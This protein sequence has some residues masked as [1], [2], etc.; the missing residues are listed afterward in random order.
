MLPSGTFGSTSVNQ[1]A[2]D[3]WAPASASWWL[4]LY[5]DVVAETILV[6]RDESEVAATL[7]FLIRHL[8][9]E[10]GMKVFDQC[11]GIG[12]LSLPLARRGVEILGVDQCEAYVRRA[13]VSAQSLSTFCEYR[14]GD[15]FA[16]VPESACDAAFNWATSFGYAVDDASNARML[17]RAY[18]S[19]KPGSL[20]ALDFI[21]VA[22]MFHDFF[23]SVVRRFSTPHGEVLVIQEKSLQLERGFL[24]QVW[25]F[26]LPSGECRIRTSSI[27]LYLAHRIVEMLQGCG[28]ADVE[29]FGSVREEPFRLSSPRC[30]CV[31]RRP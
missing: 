5:D 18:E 2:S 6:S 29:I 25:T 4:S 8:R 17:R 24:D 7:E 1:P 15:A 23:P 21:N 31:A 3:D 12:G 11:C 28:F 26:V 10:P 22:G 9:L 19:L 13:Q 20:F 27:R 16:F 30:I 14:G